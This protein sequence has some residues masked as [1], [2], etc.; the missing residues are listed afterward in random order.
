MVAPI[1][2]PDSGEARSGGEDRGKEPGPSF[3]LGKANDIV[4]LVESLPARFDGAIDGLVALFAGVM[5]GAAGAEL[6]VP[7]KHRRRRAEEED[8]GD[9]VFRGIWCDAEESAPLH[10]AMGVGKN[11]PGIVETMQGSEIVKVDTMEAA[12]HEGGS[13][14]SEE[15][16]TIAM[17][18][19]A[20]REDDLL[21]LYDAAWQQKLV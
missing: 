18:G 17:G 21:D 4:L 9:C 19:R 12:A 8:I 11:V 3:I 20:S 2:Y 6:F 15:A 7:P 5:S 13:N 16:T 14:E 1:D 10:L